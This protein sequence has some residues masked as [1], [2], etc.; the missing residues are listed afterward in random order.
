MFRNTIERTQLQH[1]AGRVTCG[2]YGFCDQ[3]CCPRGGTADA[4]NNGGPVP[5][6][7]IRGWKATS[8]P[9]ARRDWRYRS[10]VLSQLK[11]NLNL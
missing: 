9:T 7:E 3:D 4:G 2:D 10:P 1:D 6:I 8:A 5:C 11:P